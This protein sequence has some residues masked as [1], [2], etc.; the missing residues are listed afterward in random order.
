M[1]ITKFFFANILPAFYFLSCS[2]AF[3][4]EYPFGNLSANPTPCEYIKTAYIWGLG[5]VGT[6]AVAV[7]A[8]GGFLYMVGKVEQG[9]DYITSAFLGILLLFG[10]Y[11]ILYT[12]NPELAQLKC[13][14]KNMQPLG[15]PPTGAS[16]PITPGSTTGTSLGEQAARGALA[17]GVGVKDACPPGQATGC[18]RMEGMKDTTVNEINDL[19]GKV[20]PEN[21][22]ISGGTEGCGATGSTIHSTGSVSHCSGDKYDMRQNNTVNN[23]IENAFVKMP[24]RKYDGA[25]MWMDPKTGTTYAKEMG[26]VGTVNGPHWDVAVRKI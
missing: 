18:V 19:A 6:L 20:G 1:K 2:T 10:A 22:Y 14:I 21:I 13:E 23:Y 17:S 7:I 25:E 5:I 16:V 24:N 3:A 15:T 4:L 11:L 9:K 8:F 12:I 26:V